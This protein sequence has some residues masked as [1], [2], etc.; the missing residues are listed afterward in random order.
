MKK[1][2]KHPNVESKN[3]T[4]EFEIKFVKRM[5][6]ENFHTEFQMD[7]SIVFPSNIS[8]KKKQLT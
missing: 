8:E 1:N 2:E 6:I 3:I 5:I 4:V 7:V